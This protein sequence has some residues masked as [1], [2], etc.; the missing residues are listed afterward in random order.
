MENI[1]GID[2]GGTTIKGGLIEGESMVR[3]VSADTQAQ[4]GGD[5]TLNILKGVIISIIFIRNWTKTI[6]Y[7]RSIWQMDLN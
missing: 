6:L 7:I 2:M 1:I 5:V 3:Q 4:V